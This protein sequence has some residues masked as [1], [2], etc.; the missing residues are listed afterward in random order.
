MRRFQFSD[1]EYNKLSAVVGVSTMDLQKLDAMGLLVNEVAVRIVFE[2]EYKLQRKNKVLPRLI[3]QAI[4]NKYG[5]PVIKVKKYLYER[6]RPVFYCSKCNKEITKSER[7]K[8]DGLCD[9]CVIDNIQ[10]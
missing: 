5:M 10:L 2:Y 1:E 3:M 7:R 6:E 9:Q 8:N 4:A